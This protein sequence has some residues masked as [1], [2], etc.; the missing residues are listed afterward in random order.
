MMKKTIQPPLLPQCVFFW[1]NCCPSSLPKDNKRKTTTLVGVD[2][3]QWWRLVSN[4]WEDGDNRE[5]QQQL[6]QEE[7]S[8]ATMM[9][10]GQMLTP[11]LLTEE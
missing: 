10:E 1:H 5:G 6:M 7:R 3:S 4:K 8:T 2:V 11:T 9:E